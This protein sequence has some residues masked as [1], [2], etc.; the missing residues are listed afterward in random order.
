MKQKNL[1]CIHLVTTRVKLRQVTLTH[2]N[3]T[4]HPHWKRVEEEW[5]KKGKSIFHYY[6]HN[7]G[8]N[9]YIAIPVLRNVCIVS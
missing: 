9:V 7:F 3:L 4:V 1:P 8:D 2:G 5:Q 6:N